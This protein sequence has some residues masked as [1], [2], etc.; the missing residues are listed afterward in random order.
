MI[1]RAIIGLLCMRFPCV[2]IET[3]I[4]LVLWKFMVVSKH[5]RKWIYNSLTYIQMK[6]SFLHIQTFRLNSNDITGLEINFLKG[7]PTGLTGSK[8]DVVW[9]L[10]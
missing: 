5:D 1:H 2:I 10:A 8:F 3:F 9:C 6:Q 7:P 4:F